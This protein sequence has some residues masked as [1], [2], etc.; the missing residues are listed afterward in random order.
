MTAHCEE[1]SWTGCDEVVHAIMWQTRVHP[2]PFCCSKHDPGFYPTPPTHLTANS[3]MVHR[4]KGIWAGQQWTWT[5]AKKPEEFKECLE[6]YFSMHWNRI[7]VGIIKKCPMLCLV[8]LLVLHI[9][10]FNKS[11]WSACGKDKH[12]EV[13]PFLIKS[14]F[15]CLLLSFEHAMW[16]YIRVAYFANCLSAVKQGWATGSFRDAC[17]PV[18]TQCYPQINF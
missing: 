13:Y 10:I 6:L 7:W 4:Q 11:L 2:S 1:A 5:V 14:S 3:H 15:L 8:M 9:A 16:N 18:L 12:I 17:A